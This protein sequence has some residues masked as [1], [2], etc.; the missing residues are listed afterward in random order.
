MSPGLPN[1]PL[2][3][4]EAGFCRTFLDLKTLCGPNL[5]CLQA[6]SCSPTTESDL[7]VFS[8]LLYTELWSFFLEHGISASIEIFCV[9]ILQS[10]SH[11]LYG[12]SV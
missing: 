8:S 5:T 6:D 2:V 9:Y 4:R 10:D 12:A 1:I 3:S 11:Q 7:C